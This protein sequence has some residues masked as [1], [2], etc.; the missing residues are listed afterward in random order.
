LTLPFVRAR[1]EAKSQDESPDNESTNNESFARTTNQRPPEQS[2]DEG[3]PI[4]KGIL[5][6]GRA[7]IPY[8]ILDSPP[9]QSRAVAASKSFK[10]STKAQNASFANEPPEDLEVGTANAAK[11]RDATMQCINRRQHTSSD[12]RRSGHLQCHVGQSEDVVDA[13]KAPGDL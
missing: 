13:E 7:S 2:K 12:A 10:S 5:Q 3:N 11:L 4:S 6:G 9:R 8:D 1:I